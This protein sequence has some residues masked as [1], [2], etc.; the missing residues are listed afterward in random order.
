MMKSKRL[1]LERLETREVLSGATAVCVATPPPLPPHA[2]PAIVATPLAASTV[3]STVAQ[4]LA[5]IVAPAISGIGGVTNN[6]TGVCNG[7]VNETWGQTYN[8]CLVA[9][10]TPGTYPWTISGTNFGSSWGTV[11][12]NGRSVPILAWSNTSIQI[13]VSGAQFNPQQP[14]N[15]GPTCSNLVVTTATHR[16][17]SQGVNVVPALSG[18]IYGQCTYGAA[19]ER[20]AM[21]LSPILQPYNNP[22]QIGTNWVPQRGDQ[23]VWNVPSLGCQHTAVITNVSK[24]VSG[25]QTVYSLTIYQM[26]ADLRNSVSTF[27][28]TF[29]VTRQPNGQ[30]T[31]SASPKFSANSPGAGWYDR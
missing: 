22:P 26:N 10:N 1:G 25:N 19:Y 20:T 4:Q 3:G 28:T 7:R 14:W 15:W 21:G 9:N 23:L 16:Q 12:L 11:T 27:Q 17:V 30:L 31:V 18:L 13:N 29:T 5:T 2:A 24:T 6:S 8:G